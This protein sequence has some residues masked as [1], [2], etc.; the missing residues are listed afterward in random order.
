MKTIFKFA[1]LLLLCFNVS[2]AALVDGY[3]YIYPKPG[4]M[5]VSPH[6]TIILRFEKTPPQAIANLSSFVQVRENNRVFHGTTRIAS[7]DE[8]ILFQPDT[9]FAF[10]A[11]IRVALQPEC[12][13]QTL[14]TAKKTEFQFHVIGEHSWSAPADD[15]IP[16]LHKKQKATVAGRAR[17][18]PNGVSVP[19]DFP[20]VNVSVNKETADG[21]I[22]LNNW[23]ND[24]PYNILFANDGSPVWYKRTNDGDRRR[25]FKVQ[26]NGYI[27][28]LVRP[29]AG[30][31]FGQGHVAYDENFNEVKTFH[32]VD[33]C[34]T[35]EHELQVL[36]NGNYLL[37]G[38]KNIHNVDMSQIVPGGKKSAT[39]HE[40]GIQEFTADGDLIFQWRAWDYFDPN[41][42]I[43]FCTPNEAD[44][45]S[46]SF[47]F[48]HMNAIDIDYDGHIL[49]SS[50]HLSEVTKIHRQTGEII[51][52]LC[53]ANSDFEFVNDDLNGFRMQHDIRSLGNNHY[54]VFDNGNMHN[55]PQS[56]AVEYV[57]DMDKKTA[58]LVWEC[59]GTAERNY[60]THY[61]GNAQRLPNNNTLINWVYANS[62]KAME[63]TP[64]GEVVYSMDFVEGFNTYRT[65]RFPWNGV[66]EKPLLFV[67]QENNSLVL[68]FNKFGDK[69]V[70][71][72]NIYGGTTPRP[73]TVV[74]TSRV[75]LKKLTGLTNEQRYYFRVTAVDNAGVESD[76]SN[77]EDI[78]VNFVNP[79]Q[80][81]I[82]NGSFS[83]ETE[84]WD[85]TTTDAT[86]SF[87]VSGSG[88]LHVQISNAG[89]DFRSIQVRQGDLPLVRGKTYLFEFDAYSTVN[90]TIEAYVE[91]AAAPWTNY[92]R[93]NPTGLRRARQHFAYE[94][95]MENAS[96]FAAQ[97]VFNCGGAAGD[98]F[99]DNVSLTNID[100]ELPFRDLPAMWQ[101][102][103]IGAVNLPGDAG[104]WQDLYLVKG[105]GTDIWGTSDQ[106]HFAYQQITGDVEISAR[107][108][109]I[110]DTDGW[111]KAGVMIR[112]SL[113]PGAK[114]AMMCATV[115]N[116][117]A[118][119]RRVEANQGSLNDNTESPKTP[120]WVKLSRRGTFFIGYE[121][122]DGEKWDR[123]TSERIQMNQTVYVGF[124]V[125]SHNN[126][127]LCEAT[128]DD[129]QMD[130]ETAAINQQETLLP[131]SFVLYPA[132]PNPFNP[133]TTIKY[134][135]P[136]RSHI[137]L[138]IYNIRGERVRELV[139][140]VQEAGAYRC[141][142][143]AIDLSSGL[144]LYEMQANSLST[145][146]H[147]HKVH[148][149][150]MV[151]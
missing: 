100:G 118:F 88:E 52:R 50:R 149:M 129:L 58:T 4:A 30:Y 57:L 9:P 61:M 99:I 14:F 39:I 17:I 73:T 102:R 66:V 143:D 95:L 79:G 115:S 32:A 151:R 104:T 40:T 132:F 142:F 22:F 45:T 83:N 121:S 114:H 56:R 10:G 108:M 7:D 106:F 89:S 2:H 23:R 60:Y 12:D 65:F 62:P 85:F 117:M 110:G 92:G 131:S 3:R 8:T 49:L 67:E 112:N 107:V 119:Q 144:Y 6:T 93:L 138:V 43:G 122:A 81:I 37:L 136:E 44:P 26:R 145:A 135:L 97:I 59:R 53:G 96:D 55:P 13:P 19:S 128:F 86:A 31:P 16:S 134:N 147:F 68:I 109:S 140:E 15:Q 105:S 28:M 70:A 27:T 76:F 5:L 126:N 124:A 148:K 29:S 91:R 139:N 35:D 21:Y 47:R 75:T 150:T 25:D 18:M 111:A 63:V 46:N 120:Y 87:D 125:T 11:T 20:H 133:T 74:D 1:A 48:P 80:N 38:L 64:D 94:F 127:A 84:N 42:I 78:F 146:L 103:D 71:Y 98:V 36:E 41:D 82:R 113:E 51:W 24:N 137:R 34:S 130:Y 141:E 69:N 101:H 77:E 116:G 123:I 72:Y 33:G 54:T 90:R